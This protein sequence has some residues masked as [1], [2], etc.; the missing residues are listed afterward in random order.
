M[1][2][3]RR[4]RLAYEAAGDVARIEVE[5]AAEARG[6]AAEAMASL[7]LDAK[8]ALVGVDLGG[9]GL[10]RMVVMVGAHEDVASTRETIVGLVRDTRGEPR[11]IR[12]ANARATI[13]V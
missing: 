4:A 6:G 5:G 13:L 11:E 1:L 12:V 7:L 9:E 2:N 3:E 8:G 10:S